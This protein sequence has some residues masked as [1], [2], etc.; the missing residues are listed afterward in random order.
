MTEFEFLT[1]AQSAALSPEELA[2]YKNNVRK[3][4]IE[5]EAYDRAVGI[6][7]GKYDSL[8]TFRKEMRKDAAEFGFEMNLGGALP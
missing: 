6:S 8:E 4:W 1:E 7:V 5:M 3:M 2:I